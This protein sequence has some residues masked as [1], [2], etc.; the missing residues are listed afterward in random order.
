MMP[1]PLACSAVVLAAAVTALLGGCPDR[2]S[3]GGAAPPSL[4]QSATVAPAPAAE[5][6]APVPSAAGC[7]VRVEPWK[8]EVL[9]QEPILLRVTVANITTEPVS[10]APPYPACA[11]AG[12]LTADV[13]D[14]GGER[15][16]N[17]LPDTRWGQYAMSWYGYRSPWDSELAARAV[18]GAWPQPP[19]TVEPDATAFMWFDLLTLYP[20]D[21]PGRYHLLFR[22]RSDPSKLTDPDDPT[23]PATAAAVN[24]IT[25]DA[26]WV[27]IAPP[28]GVDR[29]AADAVIR[30]RQETHRALSAGLGTGDEDPAIERSPT[31]R[32]WRDASHWAR[33]ASVATDD[34][35]G[36]RRM[37]AFVA[38]HPDFPL[39]YRF[40]VAM[41]AGR[42]GLVELRAFYQ[43]AG[44]DAR[45]GSVASPETLAE[46]E[47]RRQEMLGAAR[48]TGDY[49]V[50]ECCLAR[51][52]FA[53][54]LREELA[55]RRSASAAAAAESAPATR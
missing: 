43:A 47:A 11:D 55:P 31:F 37:E 20:L 34:V 10:L 50:Y 51:A 28:T 7:E 39:N 48:A 54:R 6:P 53:Q 25:I 32:F 2:G 44:P 15:V 45:P 24:E 8:R 4:G 36:A 3:S 5:E 42:Y 40:P 33:T 46:L 27:T 14:E 26:G 52:W 19:L 23:K 9:C 22:Y 30:W 49:Y 38:A 35:R 17:S 18:P 13:L 1:R 21:R 41:A 12:T 16:P 29:E